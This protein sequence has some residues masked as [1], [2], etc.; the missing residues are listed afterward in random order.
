MER[1]TIR[2][3]TIMDK[4]I[5]FYDGDCGL[6]NHVFKVVV[7]H[8]RSKKLYF[9]SLQSQFTNDFFEENKADL[10]DMSTF[11]LY[12]NYQLFKKSTAA[13]RLI[14]YLKWYFFPF[15]IFYLIPICQRDQLYDWVARNRKKIVKNY[16]FVPDEATKKRILS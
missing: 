14:K 7:R 4:N 2:N 3:F 13:L 16:C 9:A 10:P 11:Y 5:I 15:Y 1:Q 6:C 8:E 12:E